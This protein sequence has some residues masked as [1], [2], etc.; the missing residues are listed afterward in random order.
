MTY[1]A[2][3]EV[4]QSEIRFVQFFYPAFC[5]FTGN[6]LFVFGLANMLPSMSMTSKALTLP[7]TAAFSMWSLTQI[8]KTFNT[9]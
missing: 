5:D 1:I 9:K 8:N 2:Q 3:D 7:L 4:K 6:V